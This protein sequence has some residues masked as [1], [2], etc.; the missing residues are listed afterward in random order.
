MTRFHSQ[1]ICQ[2]CGYAQVGWSGKCPNCGEWNSLVETVTEESKT[3]STSNANRN[4]PKLEIQK[5]TGIKVAKN[6]RITTK[7]PE[8][9]RVLGGGMVGG[10]VILLAGE[11]GIGKSTIL[12]QLANNLD[13]C[14]YVSGEES[15]QQVAI[16]A[17]RLGINS[18]TTNF[19][20]STDIDSIIASVNDVENCKLV[21]IDSIQ[22]MVTG[23]LTGLAGSV[24]QVR[25]CSA[26]LVR[27]A[28]SKNIPVFIVGHVTKEKT[29]AGPSTLAHIVDTV[30]WFEGDKTTNLRLIRSYKN[31][32]GATDEVGIFEMENFGLTS[33]TNPQKLFLSET[34]SVPGSIVTSIL[35][36]TRPILVEIQS[37]VVATKLPF[38]KRVA[39]GIDARRLEMLIAILIKRA[40]LPLWSQDIFVNVTG[41]ISIKDPAADLAVCLCIA[42]AFIE[43]SLQSKV[44]AIGEVGLLGEVRKVISED[45][46]IKEATRLGYT[47]ISQNSKN[48]YLPQVINNLL[49][50]NKNPKR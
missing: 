22:T 5:L 50:P 10:Q 1:Y 26:R 19:L 47:T 39:Q 9:D 49:L 33:I 2:Q 11:P 18:K 24:G 6:E 34:K 25:E 40:N 35:E 41:G 43:K 36:G 23:D 28:K 37:L 32:F 15:G 21:I 16:R 13:N 17:K 14:L 3:K 7:I 48:Q 29:V 27:F 42:S 30:L 12:L 46:R 38:P 45:K 20:D 4:A 8:F 44:V 31:R